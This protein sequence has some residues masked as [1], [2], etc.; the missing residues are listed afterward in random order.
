MCPRRVRPLLGAFGKATAQ[1]SPVPLG[2]RQEGRTSLTTREFGHN[3]LLDY[4]RFGAALVIVLF[5]TGTLFKSADHAA[6]GFFAMVLT[7]FTLSGFRE[8]RSSLPDYLKIRARRLLYPCLLWGGLHVFGK[9]AAMRFDIAELRAD[10]V[11]WLPP[12]GTMAQ[13]WFLPWAFACTVLLTLVFYGRPPASKSG[14]NSVLMTGTALATCLVML[15]LWT[16]QRLPLFWSI[17]ALYGTSVAIGI[18]LFGLRNRPRDLICAS[19]CVVLAG[20][21]MKLWGLSG[22]TQMTVACPLFVGALLC[23]TGDLPFAKTLGSVSFNLY[24]C[25]VVVTALAKSLL[26]VELG[27]IPGALTAGLLS[28]LF[29]FAMQATRLGAW[30]R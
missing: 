7:Y 12:Q 17:W 18:L 23:R 19:L 10:L 30:L 9:A 24:L 8:P 21:A 25:H 6:V 5:H 11:G 14:R 16:L 3:A 22:T 2:G 1:K 28:V 13:L 29:A 15:S 27:T 4:L 20:A 26:G